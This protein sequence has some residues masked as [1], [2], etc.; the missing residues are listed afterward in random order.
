MM[1]KVLFISGILLSFGM[2]CACSSD[3]E[4]VNK[5]GSGGEY[6]IGTYEYEDNPTV[7]EG[8]W[9]L[10]MASLGFGNIYEFSADDVTVHFNSNQTIKVTNKSETEEKKPFMDS[11]TYSYEIVKTETNMYDGTVYTTIKLNERQCVYWIKD[12]ML[13]LDYGVAHDAEGFYFKKL[14]SR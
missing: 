4:I 14:K 5:E 6:G 1:K 7:L 10:T 13:T 11:G 2:F 9:H 12:G 3:D 8:T